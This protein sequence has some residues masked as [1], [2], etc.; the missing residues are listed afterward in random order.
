MYIKILNFST[1]FRKNI[2]YEKL[3]ENESGLNLSFKIYF[4]WFHI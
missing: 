1:R 4:K 3:I 2:L